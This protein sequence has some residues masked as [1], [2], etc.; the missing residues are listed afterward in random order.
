MTSRAILLAGA[1]GAALFA[2]PFDATRLEVT[3]SP[4]PVVQNVY[5]NPTEGAAQMSFSTTGVF[6]YLRGGPEVA[7]YPIVLVDR[8][9]QIRGYYDCYEM[10]ELERLRADIRTVLKEK[11]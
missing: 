7:T 2:V 11:V 3:G 4:S 8:R 9:G 1:A 5:W 10:D 6:A